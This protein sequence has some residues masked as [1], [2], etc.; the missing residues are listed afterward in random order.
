MSLYGV[1]LKQDVSCLHNLHNKKVSYSRG[2]TFALILESLIGLD[3]MG[4]G[5]LLQHQE[6][7]SI[8]SCACLSVPLIY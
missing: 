3:G 5:S 4:T 7:S 8:L 2:P 6:P 1:D